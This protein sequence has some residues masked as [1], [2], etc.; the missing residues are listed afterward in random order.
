MNRSLR[1]RRR[2]QPHDWQ[3]ELVADVTTSPS[4]TIAAWYI[5]LNQR[6][7]DVLPPREREHLLG[8]LQDV[9]PGGCCS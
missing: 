8:R 7:I 4:P 2:K 1:H 3:S 6:R 9:A 5:H